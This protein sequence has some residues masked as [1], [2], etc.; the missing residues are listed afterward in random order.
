M[1][2]SAHLFIAVLLALAILAPGAG[3]QSPTHL[4]VAAASGGGSAVVFDIHTGAVV[5][6]IATGTQPVGV[7][8]TRDNRR[9]LVSDPTDATITR[10][11]LTAVPPV[12]AGSF[13]TAP[14]ETA[15]QGLAVTPD[16]E[17]VLVTGGATGT[18]LSSWAV[19]TGSLVSQVAL[20]GAQGVALTPDGAL[21][22]VNDV[23][24]SQIS[25]VTVGPGGLLTDTGTRVETP[26][27]LRTTLDRLPVGLR[28]HAAAADPLRRAWEEMVVP[29]V[30]PYDRDHYETVWNAVVRRGPDGNPWA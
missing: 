24:G 8:L 22:L 25:L 11:D 17:Y 18:T 21:A 10:L 3:A 9:A 28:L 13:S 4:G 5:A 14:T 29:H 19:A 23:A 6:T 30:D 1:R 2:R 26:M 16:G 20:P 27:S 7:A 12:G 15:P